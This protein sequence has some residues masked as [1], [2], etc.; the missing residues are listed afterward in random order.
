MLPLQN[1]WHCSSI[2]VCICCTLLHYRQVDANLMQRL[3]A[4]HNLSQ[5]KEPPLL[6][7]G[8][9]HR[10]AVFDMCLVDMVDCVWPWLKAT[11]CIDFLFMLAA[12]GC[13]L[14]M[15]KQGSIGYNWH[16]IT[17]CAIGICVAW[18]C[19]SCKAW[20]GKTRATSMASDS[21]A[22]SLL[23]VFA[24]PVRIHCWGRLLSQIAP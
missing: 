1:P 2:L 9:W 7:W 15:S 3:D 21:S 23:L 19:M 24:D 5:S 10:A 12:H 18:G 4:Y 22:F 16:L 6:L 8:A 17:L 11:V 13:F 20:H 14:N